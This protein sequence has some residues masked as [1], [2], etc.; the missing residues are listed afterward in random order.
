MS[1]ISS[2]WPAEP[3]RDVGTVVAVHHPPPVPDTRPLRRGPGRPKGGE[4]VAS[5]DQ[6]LVAA[7]EVIRANGPEVTMDD[8][9]A[10]ADVT[11]PVLYRTIGDKNALV[12]A[13]SERLVDAMS[14]AVDRAISTVPPNDSETD[15]GRAVFQAAL[16]GSLEVIDEDRSLFVFVNAGGPG[17][18]SFRSLVDRSSA[19]MVERFTVLRESAGLD[20]APARTWAYAMVGAIQVVAMMWLRDEYD[21]LDA[22]AAQLAALMWPGVSGVGS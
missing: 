20:A 10:A 7:I 1:T 19:Q 8:I 21:D 13:L 12:G 9:A 6:L 5:K 16:R 22:V 14:S 3:D 15:H 17:T 4:V 18:E 2:G 11:K